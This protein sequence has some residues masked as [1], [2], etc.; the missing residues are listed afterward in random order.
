MQPQPILMTHYSRAW[1]S[2]KPSR[3]RDDSKDQERTAKVDKL[4]SKISRA[5]ETA[6]GVWNLPGGGQV[7]SSSGELPVHDK[8]SRTPAPP[9][10][11]KRPELTPKQQKQL[12]R[13]LAVMKNRRDGCGRLIDQEG[14]LI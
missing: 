2:D 10:R 4:L 13:C 5:E 7:I 8:G 12:E 6:P 11:P 3:R 1:G 9:L 14:N